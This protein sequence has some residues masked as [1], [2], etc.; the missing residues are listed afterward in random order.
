MPSIN[1]RKISYCV[2]G[3]NPT[4]IISP[5]APPSAPYAVGSGKPLLPPTGGTKSTS[6]NVNRSV[7]GATFGESNEICVGLSTLVRMVELFPPFNPVDPE[8]IIP[9]KRPSVVS[10]VRTLELTVPVATRRTFSRV[11]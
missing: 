4:R 3:V 7:T 11:R 10:S 6:V 8:T 2:A 5:I 9:A 1:G